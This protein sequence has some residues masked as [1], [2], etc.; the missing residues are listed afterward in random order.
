MRAT[1][2]IA[3]ATTG[4]TQASTDDDGLS[5]PSEILEL[6]DMRATAVIA[7]ATTSITQAS[8]DD[9]QAIADGLS[10]FKTDISPWVDPHKWHGANIAHIQSVLQ[11]KG[12]NGPLD[13][14]LALESCMTVYPVSTKF[15][16]D[17]FYECAAI[18]IGCIYFYLLNGGQENVHPD[19]PKFLP[20]A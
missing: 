8:M 5:H 17:E 4:I 15:I 19:R 1:T 14:Y 9:M 2:V 18:E 11:Q 3:Q 13:G 12:S 16:C 6:S 7:Q 20:R 10:H